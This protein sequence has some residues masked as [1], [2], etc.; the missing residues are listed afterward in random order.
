MKKIK[1]I[2][3]ILILITAIFCGNSSV[4]A[5]TNTKNINFKVV[6]SGEPKV[7]NE[8]K[9]TA[10]ITDD[11]NA[12]INVSDLTL[13]ENTEKATYVVQNT[14]SE[15]SADLSVEVKNNNEEYF[16]VDA[17]PEKTTLAKGEATT[18]IVTVKLLKQP[19]GEKNAV[20]GIQLKATP[21]E[22]KDETEKEEPKEEEKQE[23]QDNTVTVSP[24]TPTQNA[25]STIPIIDYYKKDE[26]PKTGEWDLLEIINTFW[27]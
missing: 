15:L 21:I 10:K 14:S 8:N 23:N 22:P 2:M 3:I 25:D 18:V 5:T 11:I 4:I 17:K 27:R 6:F 9:V 26:T 12:T 19:E 24:S 16:L 20:I 13:E 7:S 1:T